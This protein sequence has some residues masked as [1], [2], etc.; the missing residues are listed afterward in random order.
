MGSN[1]FR[2]TMPS[3]SPGLLGLACVPR[4]FLS[5]GLH[6][7]RTP[8]QEESPLPHSVRQ[9]HTSQPGISWGKKGTYKGPQAVDKALKD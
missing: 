3:G 1:S 4:K 8:E 6:S 2:G 9:D 7:A 5:P